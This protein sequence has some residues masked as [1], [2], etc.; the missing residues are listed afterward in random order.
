MTH[1]TLPPRPG[2]RHSGPDPGSPGG[3]AVTYRAARRTLVVADRYPTSGAPVGTQGSRPRL[4]PRHAPEHPLGSL[5]SSAAGA[6]RLRGT[7]APIRGRQLMAS[8]HDVSP[9]RSSCG[10]LVAEARS[11]G[12]PLPPPPNDCSVVG[13]GAGR[14]APPYERH[15]ANGSRAAPGPAPQC[16][17][18]FNETPIGRS[19]LWAFRGTVMRPQL[20]DASVL[21]W[22][23]RDR[24]APS[25]CL[26]PRCL[27][28]PN[29]RLTTSLEPV[30]SDLAL[31]AV[32]DHGV[33][34]VIPA[35]PSVSPRN[36][37]KL[38]PVSQ[39]WST[40]RRVSSFVERS[41]TTSPPCDGYRRAFPGMPRRVDDPGQPPGRYG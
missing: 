8:A 20:C 33:S 7:G 24:K 15:H 25:S 21:L 13:G 6:G 1:P 32:V 39:K 17:S 27:P 37:Q 41:T 29:H 40:C 9:R 22:P 36:R 30:N 28:T 3:E 31:H 26:Q 23:D 10:R 19:P 5:V 4:T 12:L 18:L 38:L 35:L 34:K 14:G 16:A 2:E 11:R